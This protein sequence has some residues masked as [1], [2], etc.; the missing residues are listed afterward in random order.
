MI[1]QTSGILLMKKE[2]SK[3]SKLMQEHEDLVSGFFSVMFQYFAEQ[4]GQIQKISTD[5]KLVLVKK[6]EGVY[7]ALVTSLYKNDKLVKEAMQASTEEIWL[8]NKKLE[9]IST[10][11]LN[12]ISDK[13]GANIREK[14]GLK[15]GFCIKSLIFKE[16]DDDIDE[17]VRKG[18]IESEI[19]KNELDKKMEIFNWIYK[20]HKTYEMYDVK[21]NKIISNFH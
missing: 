15:K 11:I 4:F 7:V 20:K 8:M 6:T 9:Q 17:F 1:F 10:I 3:Y 16:I 5:E 13:V 18:L 21:V 2:F 14:N 12:L 19:L